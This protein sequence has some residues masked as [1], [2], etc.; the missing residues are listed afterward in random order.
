MIGFRAL[1]ARAPIG[2]VI[3]SYKIYNCKSFVQGLPTISC[4]AGRAQSCCAATL[5]LLFGTERGVFRLERHNPIA[6]T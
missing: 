3:L 6:Q 2:T 4:A 5:L 1:I